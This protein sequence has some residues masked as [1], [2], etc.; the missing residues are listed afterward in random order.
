MADLTNELVEDVLEPTQVS[1]VQV[2]CEMSASSINKDILIQ[3][4]QYLLDSGNN[5]LAPQDIAKAIG[6]IINKV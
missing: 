4:V 5:T 2:V 6:F 1:N 3:A